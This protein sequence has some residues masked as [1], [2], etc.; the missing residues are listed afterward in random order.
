M[1]KT[2]RLREKQCDECGETS[3]VLYRVQRDSSLEWV[4]LCLTCQGKTA[5][6]NPHYVY[7]GTWKAQKRH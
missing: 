3:S 1:T 4:F 6:D 2:G 5:L 7:G